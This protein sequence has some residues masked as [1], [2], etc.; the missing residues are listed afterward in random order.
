LKRQEI[1]VLS[2]D[3]ARNANKVR[4]F[5]NK[6]LHT[7]RPANEHTAKSAIDDVLVFLEEIYL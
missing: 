6:I 5:A 3:T 2:D 4:L 7:A 1:G